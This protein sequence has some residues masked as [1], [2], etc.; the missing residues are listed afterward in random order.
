[1]LLTVQHRQS[2]NQSYRGG[3]ATLDSCHDRQHYMHLV[4][5]TL[6]LSSYIL[7]LVLFLGKADRQGA[8]AARI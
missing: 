8:Y 3:S 6:K 5:R 2:F 7:Y 1:M 4:T